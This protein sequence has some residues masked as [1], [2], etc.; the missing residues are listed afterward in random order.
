MAHRSEGTPL[1]TGR[2]RWLTPVLGLAVILGSTASVA[3]QSKVPVSPQ[4]QKIN[5]LL[6]KG[7]EDNELKPSRRTTDY[8]FI[9]RV[10]L[11]LLGRI[12]TPE[13]IRDFVDNGAAGSHAKR[14][15]LVRRLLNETK[16]QPK[17][18]GRPI[19]INGKKGDDAR[20]LEFN[21]VAEHAEHMADI[22]S[23]QLLT[24]SAPAQA[25]TE[26]HR[27]LV[28]EFKNNTPHDEFVT[29]LITATGKSDQNP[30][31]FFVIQH[32]GDKVPTGMEEEEGVYD[33]V[34]ITSRTTRL[35]LG[36]Q[37]Q[38]TQCHDHPFN[39]DWRQD[40]F[41]GV[42]AFY[43]QVLRDP[44]AMGQNNAN[45]QAVTVIELKDDRSKNPTASVFFERRSGLLQQVKA[46]FLKDINAEESKLDKTVPLVGK[47]TRREVL[48]DYVVKHDNF[49]QA[50]ANRVWAMLFGRGLNEQSA[51]DD[52]G[53]HNKVVHPELLAELGRAFKEYRF[54]HRQLLEWICTSD[55][56]SLSYVATKKVND[57]P[58]A[59][60]FFSRMP[61]K[62][63]SP[64][65]LY[66][67]I[68]T[69]TRIDFDLN[70]NAR[71][72]KREAWLRKLVRNFGDD[73][74]NETNFNGTVIQAL[75][76][77]NGPEI[78][79]ELTR[80]GKNAVQQAVDRG[81]KAPGS[82]AAKERA[83]MNE[84]FMMA[85]SRPISDTKMNVQVGKVTRSLSEY[86]QVSAE[87][88]RA[89]LAAG[90]TGL[91]GNTMYY[92][93]FQDLLWALLNTNEFILN[94]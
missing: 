71:E 48:A 39:P 6:N 13:E 15:M 21:Y 86:D 7:W 17:V 67:S 88:T 54:D 5:E 47:K 20:F 82:A 89:K 45:N 93:F 87:L 74:G 16:Y 78:Q 57:A 72:E 22:W 92:H 11:D 19:N 64:E 69:A 3:A 37:T 79:E 9:R 24:R 27:W 35:F 55:A 10:F 75:L 56:Y 66:R 94:H 14:I 44:P 28:K 77:M 90:A 25:R 85:L 31:V 81:L 83:I 50:Y 60:P 58:E 42:N 30:A 91:N 65:Q 1:P 76:L 61:L 43:R 12:P 32:L 40:N 38:C 41:W 80:P 59:E 68:M 23:V 51:F 29:K 36:L 4:T 49:S 63:M 62:S 84:L 73:E 52:F 18:A 34:P 2:W 8:E 33:A 53:E 70:Q 26:L 46:T